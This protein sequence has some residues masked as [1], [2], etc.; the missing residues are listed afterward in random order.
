MEE[1]LRRLGLDLELPAMLRLFVLVMARM[2]GAALP[3]PFFG[4]QL[5]PARIRFGIPLFLALFLYPFVTAGIAYADVPPL[6]LYYVGLIAKE[7]FTGFCMGFLASVPFHAVT[8]GGAFIDTQRG[9]TFA[10]V[11]APM[12][13]GSTSLLGSMLNLYFIVLFLALGGA[14]M[15]VEAV[16]LSYRVV[17]LLGFPELLDP[18]RSGYVELLLRHTNDMFRIGVQLA[19]PVV[20]ALFLIDMTLGI[21]NRAAPNIQVFFL[22]MGLKAVGGLIVLFVTLGLFTEQI[23]QLGAGVGRL[24][25]QAAALF[26]QG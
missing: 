6:G 10:S 13:G 17:P 4:G 23:V 26:A 25:E 22:G 18:G 21:V 8:I 19:G 20:V 15:V 2:A 5:V 14:H 9:T 7:L 3:L 1:L 11:I 16:G 24:M 12:T